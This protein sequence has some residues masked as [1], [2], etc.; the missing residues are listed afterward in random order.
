MPPA[1]GGWFQRCGGQHWLPAPLPRA[2]NSQSCSKPQSPWFNHSLCCSAPAAA[3]AAGEEEAPT[4]P[5]PKEYRSRAV[6]NVYNQ[7]IDA[8]APAKAGPA[9]PLD[10]LPGCA[11]CV[12][13]AAG[14]RTQQ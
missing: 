10:M 1:P 14:M 11:P 5:V 4:C 13:R 9:N 7:R 8:G 3:A 12:L 6:Y 2:W